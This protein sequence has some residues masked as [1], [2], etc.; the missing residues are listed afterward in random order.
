V[1]LYVVEN[2]NT[3]EPGIIDA[4]PIVNQWLANYRYE[5]VIVYSQ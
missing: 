1:E 2:K 3:A 4:R 5:H